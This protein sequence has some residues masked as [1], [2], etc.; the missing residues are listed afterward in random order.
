MRN[1]LIAVSRT[2][3]FPAGCGDIVNRNPMQNRLEIYRSDQPFDEV[4]QRLE[5]LLKD[6]MQPG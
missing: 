4:V 5:V 1:A 6:Q 3:L 2:L